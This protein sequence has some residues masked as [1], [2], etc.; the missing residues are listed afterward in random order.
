MDDRFQDYGKAVCKCVNYATGREKKSIQ[1]ELAAHMEDHAQALM[2]AGYEEDH[3]R[4]AAL[5]AMGDPS[6]VGKALN[7]EYPKVWYVLSR[8]ALFFL[9][10][11]VLHV[12]QYF[13][14]PL[15]T[16]SHHYKIRQD[17]MANALQTDGLPE[18]YPLDIQQELP[19]DCVLEIFAAGLEPSRNAD[20]YDA[21]ICTVSYCENPFDSVSQ[22]SDDLTFTWDSPKCLC[23]PNGGGGSD[24]YF[25]WN[26]QLC[27]LP[28]GTTP[29]LVYDRYGTTFSLEIPL[30][31][32]EVLE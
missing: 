26:Y 13:H 10:V 27:S 28:E 23:F 7:R 11:T 16:L 29:T 17:P 8:L 5:T 32:E 15:E 14:Y 24:N 6:E 31:W 21:Y 4:N 18:L 1:A 3:A 2:D 9:L 19:S 12:F 22:I 25:Y 30:P 20:G